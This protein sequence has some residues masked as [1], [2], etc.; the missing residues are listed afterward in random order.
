MAGPI[1]PRSVQGI[2]EMCLLS[3]LAHAVQGMC[4]CICTV[5]VYMYM[6]NVYVHANVHV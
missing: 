4:I 2:E 5:Y 3:K 1:T 6:Y